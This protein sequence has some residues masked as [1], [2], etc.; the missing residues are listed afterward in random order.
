MRE[1]IEIK[2]K[3][4]LNLPCFEKKKLKWTIGNALMYIS[5]NNHSSDTIL[6]L[7]KNH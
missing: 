4:I 3:L 6:D 1:A 2:Y 5:P 7:K